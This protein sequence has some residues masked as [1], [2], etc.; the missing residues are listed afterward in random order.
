MM[1]SNGPKRH[2]HSSKILEDF[3]YVFGG[4]DGVNWLNDLHTYN[5]SKPRPTRNPSNN[6]S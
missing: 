3:M 5:M 2:F 1:S 6:T 4:G